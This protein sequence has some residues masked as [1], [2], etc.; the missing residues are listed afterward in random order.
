[1]R[2]DPASLSAFGPKRTCRQRR[3]R[4]DLTKMTQS[5]HEGAGFAAVHDPDLLYCHDPWVW[6]QRD[7]ALKEAGC[8]EGQNA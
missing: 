2:R 3:E 5:G 7:E 6:G 8:I 4:S 1:M